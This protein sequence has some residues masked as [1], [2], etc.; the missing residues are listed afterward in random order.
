MTKAIVSEMPDRGDSL[1]AQVA[2]EVR[3]ELSRKKI[4]VNKLPGLIGESQS[5]WSRRIGSAQVALSVDDLERLSGLLELPPWRFLTTRPQNGA[6]PPSWGSGWAPRGSNPQPTDYKV[7]G[8]VAL[9]D[10]IPLTR[11]RTG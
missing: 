6:P 7:D 1:R 10:V 8:S 11:R 2:A 9:A 4:T 3:S 5:Y